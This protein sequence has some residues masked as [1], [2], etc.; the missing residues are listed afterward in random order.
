MYNHEKVGIGPG[1]FSS[2]IVWNMWIARNQLFF[3]KREFMPE[4]TITKA[5]TEAR[6]WILLQES[7]PNPSPSH[8]NRNLD[9]QPRTDQIHLYTDAAWNLTTENAGLGWIFDIAGSITSFSATAWSVTSPLMAET[10]AMR[11]AIISAHDRG[12]DSILI[13]SDS[14]VLV[15]LINNR[16]KNLE[17]A[18]II[19]DIYLLACLF[20]SISFKFIP[21]EVNVMAD[22]MAKQAMN[23]MF[24]VSYVKWK[25]Y[26][27]KNREKKIQQITISTLW[28]EYTIYFYIILPYLPLN[29]F[30]VWIFFFSFFFLFGSFLLSPFI[31]FDLYFISQYNLT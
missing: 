1:S 24:L 4:E 10:L 27:Q 20:N 26:T 11:K 18:G 23:S 8:P 9:P 29:N 31:L 14:Q 16:S 13:L 3:Q 12:L 6:E 22:S 21:R 2:W 19:N 5:I 17:I 7:P 28:L 30:S 15:T 25:V